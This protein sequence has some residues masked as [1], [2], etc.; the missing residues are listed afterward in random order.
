MP[1]HVIYWAEDSQGNVVGTYAGNVSIAMSVSPFRILLSGT[2]MVAAVNGVAT[3]G[4]LSVNV[5]GAYVLQAAATGLVAEAT[6]DFTAFALRATSL[7]FTAGSGSARYGGTTSATVTLR[8][9]GTPL[10]GDE[11]DFELNGS[12]VGAATTSANGVATLNNISL[13]GLNVGDYPL[14][15]T[16]SFAGDPN[17]VPAGA[18][19]DVDVSQEVI[20]ISSVQALNNVEASAN[21]KYIVDSGGDLTLTTPL[22][23]DIDGLVTVE[24]GGRI[25]LPG[26][27]ASRRDWPGPERRHAAGRRTSARR[28]RSR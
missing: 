1:F 8:A 11:I 28:R 3:F 17:Y 10:A 14:Y 20:T 27:I 25:T 7:G 18:A 5:A 6:Y 9:S 15:L 4:N 16:A 21:V 26:I 2:Q 19:T 12:V 24:Q 23:L 13:A 22:T